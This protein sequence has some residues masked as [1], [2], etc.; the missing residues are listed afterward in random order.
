MWSAAPAKA[1]PTSFHAMRYDQLA[2]SSLHNHTLYI[3]LE[4]GSVEDTLPYFGR[5]IA[6]SIISI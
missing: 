2:R 5:N 6:R 1:T 3:T 4:A